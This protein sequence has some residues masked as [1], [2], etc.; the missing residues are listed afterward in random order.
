MFNFLVQIGILCINVLLVSRFASPV[1][2]P[3]GRYGWVYLLLLA[4]QGG[5]QV[6]QVSLSPFLRWISDSLE[7]HPRLSDRVAR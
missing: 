6:T 2:Q 5:I 4:V 7:L 3:E 1:F